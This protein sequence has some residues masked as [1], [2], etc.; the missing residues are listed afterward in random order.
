MK[1]MHL[2]LLAGLVPVLLGHAQAQELRFQLRYQQQTEA[3]SNLYHRLFR[4]E[5]W[6]PS[7]TAV[8]V[9]DVWDYHHCLNAVRRLGEFAPRLNQVLV[10]AREQG[11]TII[12][13]PSDCM[14]AYVDHPARKR[15]LQTPQAANLP[16]EITSWCSR[17]PPEEAAVYPIDQSD[18]GEDDDPQEHKAW[19]AKLK[20]M[21]RNPSLPWQKQSAVIQIDSQKDYI[22]DQGDEVWSILEDK[23]IKNVILVGVHVNMCVLG[24]PFGLRQLVRN[25][26][27][28]VLMRDMTDTMYN[29]AR[30]P[31]VSHYTGNDLII[32]H[33]EK[34]VCPTITSDQI[35][36]GKPFHFSKDKRKHLVMVIAEKGY[37]TNQT[38][39]KFAQETLG[40]DFQV[41]YAFGDPEDRNRIPG[42]EVLKEADVVLISVRR[43]V[44]PPED[45]KL[46]RDFVAAGKPMIGIRTA[47]HA[48]NLNKQSPPEG[49]AD[50]PEF[51]QEVWGGNYNKHHQN[52]LKSTVTVAPDVKHPILNGIPSETKFVVDGSLYAVSP[53][54]PGTLPLMY[55]EVDGQE[56]EPVVWTHIR[57]NGGRSFYTSMG[58]HTDFA[59]PIFRRMFLQGILWASDVKA[60]A[61]SVDSR[62]E[63]W[64]MIELPTPPVFSGTTWS[65][66]VVR[67]PA[68]WQNNLTLKTVDQATAW[69]D[70]KKINDGKI[71][72]DSVKPGEYHLL[73]I[74]S[75]Q[76]LWEVPV[77]S[78]GKKHLELK[79]RWQVR[80]GAGDETWSNMPLPAKFGASPDI[81]YEP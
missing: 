42:L 76:L 37:L 16:D 9:C 21:G 32:S 80:A 10:K 56:P 47:S 46:L 13:S 22:S 68:S 54:A 59:S 24:R 30:W 11:M 4:E 25:G 43:R 70:G 14:P 51:D 65:R 53:L 29:P 60:D 34:F 20:A 36:G 66:C 62:L 26:K 33:I 18:G 71:P 57:E 2:I 50:W 72:A 8:I 31:Y 3:D 7:E 58:Y 78:S 73:V 19:A 67:L 69:W 63:N 5:K 1:I 74:R 41:S 17:I 44:L 61:K 77:L 81:L 52:D 39:P 6:N 48:F 12:H 35:L 45:M 40:H 23:G 64:P 38:L 49:L 28:A 27:N 75:P 15:A 55:G 79:G